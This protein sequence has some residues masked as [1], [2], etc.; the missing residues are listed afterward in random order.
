MTDWREMNWGE[1]LASLRRDLQLDPGTDLIGGVIQ[2]A[3]GA[4]ITYGAV[5]VTWDGVNFVTPLATVTHGLPSTPACVVAT[6][7]WD[8]G[9]FAVGVG[10]IGATTFQVRGQTPGNTVPAAGTSIVFWLAIG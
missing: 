9:D 10:N 3:G 5:T 7:N 8:T 2:A 6:G 4:R 1:L